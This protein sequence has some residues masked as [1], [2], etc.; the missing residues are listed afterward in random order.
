MIFIDEVI[1]DR[2]GLVERERG[3]LLK[4]IELLQKEK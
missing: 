2:D 3:V 1:N 4:E